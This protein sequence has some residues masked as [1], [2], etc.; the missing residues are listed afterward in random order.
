MYLSHR[1]WMPW[2]PSVAGTAAALDS[3]AAALDSGRATHSR[4][5]AHVFSSSH[6]IC[7]IQ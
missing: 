5:E 4:A 1:L 3:A 2:A 7:A 6:A